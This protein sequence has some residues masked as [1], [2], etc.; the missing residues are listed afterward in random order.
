MVT[1]CAAESLRLAGAGMPLRTIATYPIHHDKYTVID[2]RHVETGSFEYSAISVGE[3]RP[4]CVL[5]TEKEISEPFRLQSYYYLRTLSLHLT[6]SDA[7]L[8]P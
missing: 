5:T 3:T 8:E 1:G 2:A 4:S 6:M 7:K